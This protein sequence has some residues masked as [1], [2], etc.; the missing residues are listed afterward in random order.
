MSIA[1]TAIASGAVLGGLGIAGLALRR[2]LTSMC[3]RGYRLRVTAE[4]APEHPK[5]A[6][7]GT[8]APRAAESP[9]GRPAVAPVPQDGTVTRREA[10]PLLRVTAA[11]LIAHEAEWGIERAGAK[12]NGSVLLDAGSVRRH[13]DGMNGSTT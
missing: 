1:D 2:P 8:A 13:M 9:A 7:S 5:A 4:F 3:W 11:E 12:A 10:A 6:A